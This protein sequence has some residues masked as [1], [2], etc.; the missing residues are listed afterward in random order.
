MYGGGQG[1]GQKC[2]AALNRRAIA[3]HHLPCC[4]LP[5]LGGKPSLKTA[6]ANLAASSLNISRLAISVPASSNIL[7]IEVIARRRHS[8]GS[9]GEH[10]ATLSHIAVNGP[11]MRDNTRC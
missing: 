2:P 10:G 5:E 6:A 7:S 3:E 8:S 9:G 4:S 1:Q 11:V